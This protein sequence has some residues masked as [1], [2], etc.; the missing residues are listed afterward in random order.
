MSWLTTPIS[1][2]FKQ[3]GGHCYPSAFAPP[4]QVTELKEVVVEPPETPPDSINPDSGASVSP[5]PS[6]ADS[7]SIKVKK[8]KKSAKAQKDDDSE[9]ESTSTDCKKKQPSKAKQVTVIITGT[10]ATLLCNYLKANPLIT[11]PLAALSGSACKSAL[12]NVPRNIR[13][14]VLAL[15]VGAGFAADYLIIPATITLNLGPTALVYLIS[16]AGRTSKLWVLGKG[17]KDK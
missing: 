6:S 11:I 7:D 1:N 2:A 4:K 13:Y 8:D 15:S 12:R 14:T 17:A 16:V 9:D 5:T 3:V 10:A